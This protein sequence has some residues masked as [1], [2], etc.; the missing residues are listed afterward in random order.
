MAIR[1]FYHCFLVNHWQQ[2]AQE[3]LAKVAAYGLYDAATELC[4]GAIGS[5]HNTEI[6]KN[7]LSNFPKWTICATKTNNYELFTLNLLQK[8]ASQ[9]PSD[10]YCYFHTK[11]VVSSPL[12]NRDY[13]HHSGMKL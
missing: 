3:Q 1:V 6:L 7:T 11:G 13:N 5:P 4:L 12:R 2:L 10:V 8:Q 9:N